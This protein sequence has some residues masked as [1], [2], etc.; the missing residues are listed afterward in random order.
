MMKEQE[1]AFE[2]C[3]E[4]LANMIEKYGKELSQELLKEK[5]LIIRSKQKP[6]DIIE[7]KDNLD[8]VD[9]IRQK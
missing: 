3:I 8:E 5:P 1:V 7:V 9:A 2:R 6:N 4:F